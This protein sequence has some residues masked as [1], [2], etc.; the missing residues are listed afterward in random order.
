MS[1]KSF[2]IG[3]IKKINEFAEKSPWINF[4]SRLL[5]LKEIAVLIWRVLVWIY[6]KAL[7]KL[8]KEI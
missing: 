2:F 5:S 4:F 8:V 3:K 6:E 1:K 7:S